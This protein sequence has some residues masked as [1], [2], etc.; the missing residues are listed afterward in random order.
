[1]ELPIV[2]LAHVSKVYDRSVVTDD[3]SLAIKRG[4][5]LTLL[6]P[7]GCGKTTTLRMIAGFE[8]PTSGKIHI[9]GVDQEG[10]PPY[11]RR[12]NTVFQHYALFPHLSIEDNIAFGLTIRK[13]PRAEIQQKTHQALEMVKL[14]GHEKKFPNQLSGGQKQRVALARAIV[15]EPQVLLLDEPLGAL[16]FKLRKEMQVELKALQR[17]LG[18]TFVL[19]T[20]DQEEAL[21]LSDRIA[22]MN[23]GQIEQLDT[24]AAIYERPRTHFVADFLGFNNFLPGVLEG[25]VGD[26]IRVRATEGALLRV[27]D[28]GSFATGDRLVVGVRLE[29]VQVGR[30]LGAE[31]PNLLS[32][33]LEDSIY[34]GSGIKYLVRLSQGGLLAA[35][36]PTPVPPTLSGLPRG[37]QVDLSFSPEHAV[38]LPE[39]GAK[40]PP[41]HD[42]PAA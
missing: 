10:K 26:E 33:T 11:Q 29:K 22:V 20:H 7:S 12:V 41:Q 9:D 34:L 17:R 8:D 24:A 15:L 36:V 3:V 28:R 16:D 27:Q 18:I 39:P 31:S 1:V 14:L 4:E 23:R 21:V 13:V 32:G 37:T 25:R 40:I 6:G 19:V 42:L 38:A 35:L 5:F 2:Q 30:T